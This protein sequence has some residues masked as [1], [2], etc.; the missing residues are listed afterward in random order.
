MTSKFDTAANKILAEQEKMPWYLRAADALPGSAKS[1]KYAGLGADL[2]G[3]GAAAF[4]PVP[5][6][7]VRAAAAINNLR[8]AISAEKKLGNIQ[9]VKKLEKS[10]DKVRKGSDKVYLGKQDGTLGVP[11]GPNVVKGITGQA[12]KNMNNPAGTAALGGA[13]VKMGW[14]LAGKDGY[15]YDVPDAAGAVKDLGKEVV[16]G[17]RNPY[18]GATTNVP[19]MRNIN[20]KTNK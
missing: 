18:G 8:K 3:S 11:V 9:K 1:Y 20:L 14:D 15:L 5:G 2:I 7:R 10:L 6:G 16:S 12:L 17:F 13:K 4:L 19:D